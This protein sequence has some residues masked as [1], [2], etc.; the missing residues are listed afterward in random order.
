M[1]FLNVYYYKN[2]NENSN[3]ETLICDL[4]NQKKINFKSIGGPKVEKYTPSLAAILQIIAM[5]FLQFIYC[6]LF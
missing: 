4:S 2:K 3:Y 1:I 5:Y 6:T